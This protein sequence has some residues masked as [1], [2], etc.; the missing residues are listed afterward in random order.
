MRSCQGKTISICF[1]CRCFLAPD[2]RPI[3]TKTASKSDQTEHKHR[4][5]CQMEAT[6]YEWRHS[7]K[8]SSI[9][10]KTWLSIRVECSA[11]YEMN[12]KWR[13]FPVSYKQYPKLSGSCVW[14]YA[15]LSS[16]TPEV[17]H[18]MCQENSLWIKVNKCVRVRRV[19]GADP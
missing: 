9:L 18:K 8:I 12:I 6:I 11:A 15:S 1:D 17:T 5:Q 10:L 19:C 3:K 16:T 7:G 14:I 13:T 2:F 4:K